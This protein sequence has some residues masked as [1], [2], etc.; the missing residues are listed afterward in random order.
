MSRQRDP[1]WDEPED[2][3]LLPVMV[4]YNP[5]KVSLPNYGVSWTDD[6]SNRH[7]DIVIQL[8]TGTDVSKL[9]ENSVKL[10]NGGRSLVLRMPWSAIFTEGPPD[11][12]A[13]RLLRHP[14]LGKTCCPGH[15]KWNA[16]NE[17]FKKVK[18]EK[19]TIYST[20]TIGPF[21]HSYVFTPKW[22]SGHNYFLPQV[23]N[24]NND[25][26]SSQSP[27]IILQIFLIEKNFSANVDTP[28]LESNLFG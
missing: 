5:A 9:G 21:D 16:I 28:V 22:Y 1:T 8:P 13:T 24:T 2:G 18:G 3:P 15:P 19:D 11:Q 14:A 23:H 10:V 6:R 17:T 12:P 7:R 25:Q 4:K 20:V 27:A 26:V